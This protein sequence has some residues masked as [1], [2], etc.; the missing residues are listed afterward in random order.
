M[1]N[2]L[3]RI[4]KEAVIASSSFKVFSRRLPRTDENHKKLKLQQLTSGPRLES[5]T[6]EYEAEVVTIRTQG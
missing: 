2:E 6:L 5:M 4:W 1:N 3:E